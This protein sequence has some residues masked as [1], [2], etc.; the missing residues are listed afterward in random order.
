MIKFKT[1]IQF[2]FKDVNHLYKI[3]IEL[4]II[5]DYNIVYFININKIKKI[6]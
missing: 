6:N 2:N 1:F 4:K 5:I 3:L